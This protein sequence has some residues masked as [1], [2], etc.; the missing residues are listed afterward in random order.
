[1]TATATHLGQFVWYD[2]MTTDVAAARKFYTQLFPEWDVQDHAFGGEKTYAMIH[3]AGRAFGGFCDLQGTPGVGSHW[4]EYV[5]VE[6]YDECVAK[7]EKLGGQICG[8]AI[9]MP[10]VGKFVVARDPQGAIIKP[11]QLASPMELPERAEEAQVC[12]NELMTSDIDAARAFYTAVF[13]W[14]CKPMPMGDMGIYHIF[15]AGGKG[16]GG[17]MNLPPGAPMPPYWAPYFVVSNIDARAARAEE[18]GAKA[19]LPPTDIPS[20]G[21]ICIHCD[22][23]GAIFAMIQ[24]RP[25]DGSSAEKPSA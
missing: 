1:M 8:P 23:T 17:G 5:S 24:P 11:I 20:V 18:L 13:G 6:N 19:C 21:R 16:L 12:W 25:Q 2:L 15:E 22:P 4:A 7:I 3:A 14:E 9:D 10:N